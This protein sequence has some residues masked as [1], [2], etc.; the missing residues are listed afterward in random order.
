MCVIIGVYLSIDVNTIDVN[1]IDVN[2]IDVNTIDVNTIV[3]IIY[4]LMSVLMWI[5]MSLQ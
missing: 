4:F 2:T 5:R 3:F 1:T